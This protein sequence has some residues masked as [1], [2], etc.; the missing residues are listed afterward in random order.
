MTSYE[1][2][3]VVHPD[4]TDVNISVAKQGQ[5]EFTILQQFGFCVAI[6]GTLNADFYKIP[7]NFQQ[8]DGGVH[9]A[10]AATASDVSANLMY[11]ALQTSTIGYLADTVSGAEDDE[12]LIDTSGWEGSGLVG[13]SVG[14]TSA[15]DQ[16]LKG[17]LGPMLTGA[18]GSEGVGN[19]TD[20]VPAVADTNHDSNGDN[21]DHKLV[22]GLSSTLENALHDAHDEP[23]QH[24]LNQVQDLSGAIG[25]NL[26]AARHLGLI[27]GTD[28]S[29]NAVAAYSGQT[30]WMKVYLDVDFITDTTAVS[31]YEDT[32]SD[33]NALEDDEGSNVNDQANLV[34]RT[35]SESADVNYGSL[36]TVFLNNFKGEVHVASGFKSFGNGSD[37]DSIEIAPET[38]VIKVRVPIL[39]KF[40]VA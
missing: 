10:S 18:W 39:M 31:D 34:A 11:Q 19:A 33:G 37:T 2:L 29:T 5:V 15:G 6:D 21:L 14:G 30:F 17:I 32:L 20:I 26:D 25:S 8:A 7:L 13:T 16:I 22:T 40:P 36:D 35:A 23:I 4:I 24:L 38:N 12:I 9:D 28:L 27:T 1:N 3:N